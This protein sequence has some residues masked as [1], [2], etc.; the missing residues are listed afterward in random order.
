MQ[1]P[2]SSSN[3]RGKMRD[4]W[5]AMSVCDCV[6]CE[7]HH[8]STMSLTHLNH[9]I[10]PP[11]LPLELLALSY[12]RERTFAFLIRF[13]RARACVRVGHAPPPKSLFEPGAFCSPGPRRFLHLK[14]CPTRVGLRPNDQILSYRIEKLRHRTRAR[15]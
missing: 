3:C 5:E 15:A 2:F 10:S 6:I 12:R 9:T 4:E 7:N 1:R 13:W 11:P 8:L 14:S